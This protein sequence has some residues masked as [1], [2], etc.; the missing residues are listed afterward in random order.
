MNCDGRHAWSMLTAGASGY[1]PR[2]SAAEERLLALQAVA[3]ALSYVSPNIGT[4]VL[5]ESTPFSSPPAS[6][7]SAAPTLSATSLSAGAL[8]YGLASPLCG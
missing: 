3:S 4:D 8:P 7:S 1:L 6:A 2:R 5:A